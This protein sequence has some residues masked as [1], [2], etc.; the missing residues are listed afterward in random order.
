MG[1]YVYKRG[2]TT[3]TGSKALCPVWQGPFLVVDSNPPLYK[4]QDRKHRNFTIHHDRLKPCQDRVIP[5]WLRRRRHEM[6][7]IDFSFVGS[8]PEG[9]MLGLQSQDKLESEHVEIDTPEINTDAQNSADLEETLPYSHGSPKND[10]DSVPS[11]DL[12]ARGDTS[13]F[14]WIS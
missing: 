5:I 14:S 2:I 3:R 11:S 1:D 10:K 12:D 8:D 4:I 9:S 6:L 13:I 7:N